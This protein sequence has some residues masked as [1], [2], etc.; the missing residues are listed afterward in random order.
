M[1]QRI[2]MYF[3]LMNITSMK[4]VNFIV[5]HEVMKIALIDLCP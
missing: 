2:C 3:H 1:P 5:F 4:L